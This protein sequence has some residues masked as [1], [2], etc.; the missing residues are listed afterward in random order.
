MVKEKSPFLPDTVYHIYTHSNGDDLIFMEED[1]YHFFL[2]RYSDY[3]HP[4]AKTYAFCL[5]PNHFHLMVNIRCYEEVYIYFRSMGKK[6]KDLIGLANLS[7][8]ISKQFS[9]LLN[10]YAK[11]FNKKYER[12]GKLFTKSLIRIP[13]K[14]QIYYNRLVYYIHLNPVHHG[15]VE[16]PSQWPYSSYQIILSRKSTDLDREE[17][18]KWFGGLE[19]FQKIHLNSEKVK[20]DEFL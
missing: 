4:I 6:E 19:T 8:L 5:M 16:N 12:K 1:N 13:V 17:V 11:A 20:K 18:L 14:H 15:F 7:G 2:K 9:N 10:S 3:I